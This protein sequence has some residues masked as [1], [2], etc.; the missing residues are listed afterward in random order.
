MPT[1][2]VTGMIE[3]AAPPTAIWEVD[4]VLTRRDTLPPFLRRVAGTFAVLDAAAM[5]LI[6]G[7]ASSLVLQRT[8]GG[9]AVA[10]V[11]RVARAYAVRLATRLRPAARARWQWHHR[12]GHRMVIASASPGLYLHHLGRHLGAHAVICTEMTAVNGHL[13]GAL[14]GG[15]CRGAEKARRVLAHLTEHPSS[16]VYAY[17]DAHADHRLL[18]LADVAV[19]PRRLIS[20][21]LGS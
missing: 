6:R 21:Q 3:P 7:S 13:T 11:D 16:R 2:R 20:G 5:A 18:E 12:Q 9:L 19:S 1:V 4:G 8:L 17:A 15:P 10:D 14:R